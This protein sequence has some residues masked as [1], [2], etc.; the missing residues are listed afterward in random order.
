M[1]LLPGGMDGMGSLESLSCVLTAPLLAR[2]GLAT[3]IYSPSGR[4]GAPGPEDHNGPLHQDQAAAAL[5]LLLQRP[6]VDAGRVLVATVS[7]GLVLGLGALVRHPEL[8]GRVRALV[9]WEG[10]GHR[11]WFEA[12][13]IGAPQGDDAFWVPREG[14]RMAPRLACPY[15]RMQSRW[16]H[17]HGP[18]AEIGREMV[19]AALA[20]TCPEVRFNGVVGRED[21]PLVD[22]RRSRQQRIL[23]EWIQRILA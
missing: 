14:V 11:R 12:V 7:F 18:D 15:W 1:L 8:A 16:D 3:L 23:V 17:V 2:H 20:G 21:A 19:R 9:D 4:E 10:P 5:R 13:G 6:E 22:A